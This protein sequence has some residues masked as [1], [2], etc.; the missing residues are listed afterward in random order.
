MQIQSI[1]KTSTDRLKNIS[2]SPALDSEILLLYSLNKFPQG[3]SFNRA[4]LRTWPEYLLNKSQQQLF[5]SCIDERI[6]GKPIAYITGYK[7]FW[8]LN[9]YVTSDT[10][11]PRPDTE[12]LVEQ[13]LNLIPQNAYWKVL[14]LGTGSGAIA[15]AIASERKNC[16]V[17][18]SDRSFAAINI[19]KKNAHRLNI[20]N[21][22]FINGNWLECF[23]KN[24]FQ[25]IVSNPPYIKEGDPHLKQAELLHEPITALTSTN[26]GLDDIE[27]IISTSKSH[28]IKPAYLLLEHGFDQAKQVHHLL[29]THQYQLYSQVKDYGDNT[30]VSIGKNN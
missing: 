2:D 16:Q 30:R 13:A 12:I 17:F 9:L 11:I 23:A 7:E 6:K 15:L 21:C 24:T 19:A 25:I 3:K 10:L 4:F 1:L 20:N 5:E 22:F 18:A 26:N 29:L 28:F 8:S 27:Q 14:D